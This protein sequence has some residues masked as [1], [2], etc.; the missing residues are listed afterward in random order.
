MGIRYKTSL[1]K[2]QEHTY[3]GEKK[4]DQLDT[5]RPK[6]WTTQWWVP[7]FSFCFLHPRLG[8]E[9]TSNLKTPMGTDKLP[10][11]KLTLPSQR[12][13]QGA[14]WHGWG[15]L[16]SHLPTP[17]R[18]H[19]ENIKGMCM[20]LY[21]RGH[22][23]T[24]TGVV[25]EKAKWGARTFTPSR[26]VM[27]CH[28]GIAGDYARSQKSYCSSCHEETPSGINRGMVGDLDF[29]LHW[30]WVAVRWHSPLPLPGQRQ[31]KTR[32]KKRKKRKEKQ[33]I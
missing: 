20:R 17:A 2:T 14:S 18:H 5:S 12:T 19:R 4:A 29:Y 30:Q 1:Y 23:N 6:E 28:L 32:S 27:R 9:E 31:E 13:W 22:P 10:Q 24:C 8:A 3:G 15:R 26:S 16:D 7:G 11:Q 21:T 25:S 33:N